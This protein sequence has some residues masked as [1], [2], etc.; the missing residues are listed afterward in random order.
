MEQLAYDYLCS[1]PPERRLSE[2]L[3]FYK[4]TMSQVYYEQHPEVDVTFTLKIRGDQHLAS[5]VDPVELQLHLNRYRRGWS[6]E[7][8]DYLATLEDSNGER[9]LSDDYITYLQLNKL[10]E[11]QVTQ[12][13]ETH[14]INVQS[15]GPAPLV[16]FWETVV[17]S[18]I[19]ELYFKRFQSSPHINEEGN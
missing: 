11:V 1:R 18:E 17:M 8:L 9:R 15:T 19:D 5:Y 14:D 7:E 2:G 12:N 4:V 3:D 16:T 10:P 6:A 13:I